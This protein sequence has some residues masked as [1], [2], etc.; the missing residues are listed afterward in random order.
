MVEGER[1]R[2]QLLDDLKETTEYCKLKKET[3]DVSLWR[4]LFGRV[5]GPLVRQST[6]GKTLLRPTTDLIRSVRAIENEMF[7]HS[8]Y[9]V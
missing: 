1:R 3:M 6:E 5:C 8:V 9:M 7:I 2:K 4:T